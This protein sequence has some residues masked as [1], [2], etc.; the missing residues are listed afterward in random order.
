VVT[1]SYFMGEYFGLSVPTPSV[2]GQLLSKQAASPNLPR[3]CPHF[4]KSSIQQP[5]TRKKRSNVV[6]LDTLFELIDTFRAS[7]SLEK[8]FIIIF[9]LIVNV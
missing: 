1:D 9:K 3:I 2:I 5:Q 6:F 8:V 4:A 7:Y